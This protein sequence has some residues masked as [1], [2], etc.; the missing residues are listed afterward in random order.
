MNM[1]KNLHQIVHLISTIYIYTI[2]V[3]TQ[4][5]LA[6]N[7]LFHLSFAHSYNLDRP[8][9]FMEGVRYYEHEDD[10]SSSSSVECSVC[11][12]EIEEGDEVRQL[13]C[14]HVFHRECI[15]R[16]IGYGNVT[17]PLCRSCVKM[18]HRVLFFPELHQ[19]MFLHSNYN[20]YYAARS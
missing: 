11:L 20:N 16:W 1:S 8:D 14:D 18:P 12:N 17:C 10:W 9:D 3:A 13:S 2:F 7:C 19:Q 4:L 6:W 15:D 5:K